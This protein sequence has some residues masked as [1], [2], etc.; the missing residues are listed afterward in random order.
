MRNPNKIIFL[1]II[2]ILSI[3]GCNE[4]DN[5]ELI[6]NNCPEWSASPSSPYFDPIWHPSGDIIGFNHMPLKEIDYTYGYDC[7]WQADYK[8]DIDSMGFWLINADG[9]NQRRVLPYYLQTPA[10]SPDGNWIAFVQGAQIFK[11]PF[12]GEKFD[13]A[14]IVQLTFEGR[15]FHPSWSPNNAEIVYSESICNEELKCGVW[16]YSLITREYEFLN[17][18]GSDPDWHPSSDSIIFLTNAI[19][20]D[21]ADIGDSIW[22]YSRKDKV[23][24][25]FKFISTPN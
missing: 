1:F 14:N 13:T 16:T 11:M 10:W 25:L 18:Y 3:F 6:T 4:K 12:D 20:S 2:T 24:T 15:N 21:G 9:T 19:N 17:K 5:E 8:H 7:P 22:F 23:K